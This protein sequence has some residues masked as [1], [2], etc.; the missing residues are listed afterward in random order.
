MLK[1]NFNPVFNVAEKVDKAA[2]EEIKENILRWQDEDKIKRWYQ[3]VH[4]QILGR[5][6]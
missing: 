5:S 6:N 3:E 2:Q 4:V 1:V